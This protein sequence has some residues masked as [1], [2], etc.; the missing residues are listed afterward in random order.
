M[1]T[2]AS[3]IRNYDELEKKAMNFSFINGCT[4]YDTVFGD[5]DGLFQ[6]NGHFFV[7]EHKDKIVKTT[8]N[9]RKGQKMMFQAMLNTGLYTI[10]ILFS[11]LDE[12]K[13]PTDGSLI[14][15]LPDGGY[16]AECDNTNLVKT[17]RDIFSWWFGNI[18]KNGYTNSIYIRHPGLTIGEI[19]WVHNS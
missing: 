13:F 19:K 10:L 12:N 16:Y 9:L 1:I 18:N 3:N 8:D 2:A 5:I 7:I 6:S 4:I 11:K 14:L 17:T 15:L